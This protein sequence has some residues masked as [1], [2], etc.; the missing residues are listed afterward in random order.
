[1]ADVT[2][3]E[4][5]VRR[6]FVTGVSTGFGRA[7]ARELVRS[8]H[9]VIGT[10]RNRG[11][12]EAL[13][14][15]GI[16]ALVMDVNVQAEVDAAVDRVVELWGAPDVVVNNAGFGMAGAVEALSLDEIRQVMETNF[17]G[18]IR[19]TQ[20]FIPVLR[21]KSGVI[22]MLSSLAG[23][24][25]FAGMG[26]YC[27]SKFAIE[28]MSES[29]AA[30]LEPFGVK[31]VLVE[32]GAFRTDFAGRSMHG[33]ARSLDIYAGRQSG[34][35]LNMMAEYT[36]H[37]PGD[38]AKAAQAIIAA[39]TADGPPSRLALGRDAFEGIGGKLDHVR[40]DLDACG[41]P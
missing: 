5:R 25:G 21:R 7:L 34:E 32:P 35:V 17:F 11:L 24:V 22:V 15:E 14:G 16:G 33:A 38:P 13:R 40:R 30:E 4:Q 9:Q 3:A 10:V 8:G 29:L 20:A 41:L 2:S 26:A 12:V 31:V 37:E 39:V 28:G 1:M 27:A 19:V 6:W 18:V 36:G 23:H